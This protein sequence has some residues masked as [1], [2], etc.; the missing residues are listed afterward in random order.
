M[1]YAAARA[2]AKTR[3]DEEQ[4]GRDASPAPC[5]TLPAFWWSRQPDSRSHTDLQPP[6]PRVRVVTPDLHRPAR[7]LRVRVVTPQSQRQVSADFTPAPLASDD[8]V[9]APFSSICLP[10]EAAPQLPRSISKS[11]HQQPPSQA[12]GR[13]RMRQAASLPE[14]HSRSSRKSPSTASRRG[15]AGG[16]SVSAVGEREV[17]AR[18]ASL[19]SLQALRLRCSTPDHVDWNRK[20]RQNQL[21]ALTT[22]AAA[23]AGGADIGPPL[24]ELFHPYGDDHPSPLLQSSPRLPAPAAAA[25]AA[26]VVENLS[27]NQQLSRL[28]RATPRAERMKPTK[29]ANRPLFKLTGSSSSLLFS[30]MAAGPRVQPRVDKAQLSS[31]QLA[32]LTRQEWDGPPSAGELLRILQVANV[33]LARAVR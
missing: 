11:C 7:H 2:D 1:A 12:H 10:N 28:A 20:P 27:T 31:S 14:L 6:N 8:T 26:G 25:A 4:L 23:E 33:A 30:E 29:Q 19:S 3:L 21:P 15:R 16:S 13:R 18:L 32:L 5:D 9:A 17:A 22:A 24:L